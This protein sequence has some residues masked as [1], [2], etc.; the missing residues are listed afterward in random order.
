M[1]DICLRTPCRRG[2]PNEQGSIVIGHCKTCKDILTKDDEVYTDKD[3]YLYCT[4][5]CAIEYHEI[6]EIDY[7]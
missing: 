1:C 4:I 3:N 5:L 6:R 2:C 7:E